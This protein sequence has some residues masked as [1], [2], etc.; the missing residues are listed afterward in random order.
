MISAHSRVTLYPHTLPFLSLPKSRALYQTSVLLAR[1]FHYSSLLR[2]GI[3]LF[4][5]T[6]WLTFPGWQAGHPL[7][8]SSIAPARWA[9][10]AGRF[11]LP[12]YLGSPS[13]RGKGEDAEKGSPAQPASCSHTHTK[14]SLPGSHKSLWICVGTETK[15][16]VFRR[17]QLIFVTCSQNTLSSI[18]NHS[19]SKDAPL[20]L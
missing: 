9:C 13:N 10:V 7:G 18:V 2:T 14:G 5:E 19:S 11:H 8:R 4:P 3:H 17:K 12:I 15:A 16:G 1:M 6:S 20:S